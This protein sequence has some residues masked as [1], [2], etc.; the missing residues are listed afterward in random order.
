MKVTK[1]EDGGF[2]LIAENS[3]DTPEQEFLDCLQG[4]C[5]KIK[6]QLGRP[7]WVVE[8]EGCDG[9]WGA[10]ALCVTRSSARECVKNSHGHMRVAKYVRV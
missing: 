7:I 9:G 2:V 3:G 5:N 6:K 8:V 1:T 4:I 10:V